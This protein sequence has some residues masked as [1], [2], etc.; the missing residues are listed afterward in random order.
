VCRSDVRVGGF[1]LP[2]IAR[3]VNEVWLNRYRGWVYGLGFGWQI[4]VGLSTYVMTA[5]VYLMI[6]LGALAG[7]PLVALVVGTGFG[8]C[9]GVAL[10]IGAR[11]TTP[12]AIR[13]MHAWFDRAASGSLGVAVI[14]QVSVLAVGV[15]ALGAGR[16]AALCLAAAVGTLAISRSAKDGGLRHAVRHD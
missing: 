12:T 13:T 6:V 11:L 3:Q 7:R 5:A 8:L 15:S 10:L 1:A 4:G 2:R 9:R 14:G 16:L